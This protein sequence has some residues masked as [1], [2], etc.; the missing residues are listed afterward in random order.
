MTR[1][2]K[3]G[4]EII[5]PDQKEERKLPKEIELSDPKFQIKRGRTDRQHECMKT[6]PPKTKKKREKAFQRDRYTRS[7]SNCE[8]S[9]P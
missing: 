2:A 9:K 1:A 5:S 7:M 6:K 3:K 4:K 8:S